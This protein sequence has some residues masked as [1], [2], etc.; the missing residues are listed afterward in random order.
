MRSSFLLRSRGL[1]IPEKL[2]EAGLQ[3][4]QIFRLALPD[5]ENGPPERVDLA[6]LSS[7]SLLVRGDLGK[8][9]LEVGFRRLT[10]PAPVTVPIAP[11]YEDR[12]LLLSEH[13]IR[14]ARQVANVKTVSIPKAMQKVPY[15]PFGLRILALDR[16][17]DPVALFRR[18][19]VAHN[20]FRSTPEE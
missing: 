10:D 18:S 5:D 1:R 8:P 13:N 4:D 7:V 16:L 20:Q 6:L 9:V 3:V 19:S 14:F 2:R 11:V 17:H 12:L 15:R